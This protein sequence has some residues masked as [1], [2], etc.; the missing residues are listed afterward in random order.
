MLKTD[1][2][3][4][5]ALKKITIAALIGCSAAGSYASTAQVGAGVRADE[6]I[7]Q[8]CPLGLKD[9]QR[10]AFRVTS[11]IM[12]TT[13]TTV[14]LLELP[15]AATVLGFEIVGA[16]VGAYHDEA[17]GGSRLFPAPAEG[18]KPIKNFRYVSSGGP[19]RESWANLPNGSTV[20]AYA[21]KLDKSVFSLG[22]R[23]WFKGIVAR[24][25]VLEG[26]PVL[27]EQIQAI[28]Q[29]LAATANAAL[30]EEGRRAAPSRQSARTPAGMP[31]VCKF[32]L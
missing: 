7:G 1:L 8:V 27:P 29:G 2:C 6:P 14:D 16:P 3:G 5:Q 25:D 19:S 31:H 15:T 24:V 20:Y 28:E 17:R 12:Q 9:E 23:K 4:K 18:Y 11:Y 32:C 26:H 30:T 21:I 10:C 22:K 13:F